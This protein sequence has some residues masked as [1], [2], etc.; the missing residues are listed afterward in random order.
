LSDVF[1]SYAAE[2]RNRIAP[3]ASALESQGWSVFWDRT[4]PAG[5][6]WRQVIGQAI[7]D[8]RCIVVAWSGDSV[9]SRWVQEEAEDGERRDILVPVFLEDVMPPWG[10]RGIQ[11]AT[12]VDW[13]DTPEH[14]AFRKLVADME[15]ILGAPPRVAD[16]E[17]EAEVRRKAEE[18]ERERAGAEARRKEEEEQQLIALKEARQQEEKQR[19][20]SKRQQAELR[21][22]RE[23]KEQQLARAKR[24]GEKE[25]RK[26]DAEAKREDKDTNGVVTTFWNKWRWQLIGIIVVIVMGAWIYLAQ[27]A[28]LAQYVPESSEPDFFTAVESLPDDTPLLEVRVVSKEGIERAGSDAGSRADMNLTVYKPVNQDRYYWLGHSGNIDGLIMVRP[29]VPGAALKVESENFGDPVWTD[30]GS[31]KPYG[32]SLWRIN[33]P[34]PSYRALGSIARLRKEKTDWDKPRPEEIKGLVVLHKSLCTD[35]TIGKMIW[36]DAGTGARQDGSVWQILPKDKDGISAHTFHPHDRHSR[37]AGQ[38]ARVYVIAKGD[39][40]KFAEE[41]Q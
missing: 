17:A 7:A 26:A 34:D 41:R 2:D 11:G 35:G 40:V 28:R 13:D 25:R 30:A 20:E 37:P 16:A 24:E 14:P 22:E 12:L 32:Y 29:L 18:E 3:I 38:D 6:T 4:I 31:G 27:S 19:A 15:L 36:S 39:G 8:A 23:A 10:F 9:E 1:I 21:K 5:K 33:P